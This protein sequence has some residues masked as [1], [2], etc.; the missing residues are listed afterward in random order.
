MND[1]A[2]EY[3]FINELIKCESHTERT[4]VWE[5]F[6]TLRKFP[7]KEAAISALGFIEGINFGAIMFQLEA[8]KFLADIEAQ[9][10]ESQMDQFYTY[11]LTVG[12][13][14]SIGAVGI[15]K[16]L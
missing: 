14:G 4:R 13:Q 9:K 6:S 11:P 7:N 5:T 15:D 10:Q 2:T 12:T 3:E 16:R 8:P 1:R